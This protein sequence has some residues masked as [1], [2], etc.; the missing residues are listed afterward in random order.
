MIRHILAVLAVLLNF[1]WTLPALAQDENVVAGTTGALYVMTNAA[2]NK[3][4]IYEREEDGSLKLEGCK[5][6]LSVDFEK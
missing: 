6:E 2:E 4:V 3:I 1:I 5:Q